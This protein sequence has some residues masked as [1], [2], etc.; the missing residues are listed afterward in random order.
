LWFFICFGAF[1]V[2]VFFK[3]FP[4]RLA[5]SIG[6]QSSQRKESSW[7]MWVEKAVIPLCSTESYQIRFITPCRTPEL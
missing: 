6:S 3:Y 1:F 2:V 5:N 4:D 7:K